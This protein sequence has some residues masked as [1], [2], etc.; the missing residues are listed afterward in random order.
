MEINQRRKT[1][2]TFKILEKK[3]RKKN[4]LARRPAHRYTR[5]KHKD[6]PNND[7]FKEIMEQKRKRD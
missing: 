1:V 5:Q 2:P 3:L 7:I 6:R 4:N